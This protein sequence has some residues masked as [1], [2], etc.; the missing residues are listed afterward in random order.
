MDSDSMYFNNI[1]VHNIVQYKISTYPPD[2]INNI[3]NINMLQSTDTVSRKSA[4]PFM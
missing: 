4:L 3:N 1:V 2:F